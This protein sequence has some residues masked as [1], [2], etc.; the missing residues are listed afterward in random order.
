MT[1]HNAKSITFWLLMLMTCISRAAPA[2]DRIEEQGTQRAAENRA[3]QVA[4]DKLADSTQD[5][6]AE[7]R[8][9]LKVI[10]GLE[11]YNGLLQQQV[12]DQREEIGA[13]EDSISQVALIER[14][15]VPLM[16]RMVDTLEQF[17]ELDVPFLLQERRDR[18]AGL[19]SLLVRSDVTAAEKLRR[20]LEAYQIENDYGRTVE[21]YTGTLTLDARVR[22]VNFLSV[23]RVALLYQTL[24][25]ELVGAWDQQQRRFVALSPAQYGRHVAQGLKIARKQAA[26][27]LLIVPVSTPG[28]TDR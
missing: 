10:E 19:R 4:I 17:I 26:P 11:V 14:Q 13:I 21:P 20:V 15:I 6:V 23:G 25:G 7:Y 27:Q 12:E 1:S 8:G 22:E 3:A 16:A 9:E 28:P 5:L 2:V 24:D 18:V